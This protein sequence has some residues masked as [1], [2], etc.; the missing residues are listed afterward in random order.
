AGGAKEGVAS[1]TLPLPV[2]NSPE[3]EQSPSPTETKSP[4]PEQS[5]SPTATNT[6][7]PEQTV[8]PTATPDDAVTVQNKKIHSS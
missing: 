8:P 7:E 6:P 4:E 2:T 3:P 5:P 1:E